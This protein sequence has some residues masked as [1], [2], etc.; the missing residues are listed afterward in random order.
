MKHIFDE[1]KNDAIFKGSDPKQYFGKSNIMFHK[2]LNFV[3]KI[4]L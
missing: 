1:L 3:P 4:A 2:C